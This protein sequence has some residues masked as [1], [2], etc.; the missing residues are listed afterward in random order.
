MFTTLP[1]NLRAAALFAVPFIAVDFFNYFSAGT[2]LVISL[3]ILALLY[4]G[5][6]MLGAKFARES[7]GGVSSAYTGA[8]TGL[9]LWAI[10][11]AVNVVIGLIL[12]TLTLGATLFASV[13]Y[14]CLC[15]P[16]QLIGGG[17][18]GAAGGWLYQYY[19]PITH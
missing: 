17:L 1:P 3:P 6:G 5:C 10:S 2:A 18:M 14:L 11:L 12:G 16:F 13:P 8:L 4:A 7:G 9:T 19:N 15:G